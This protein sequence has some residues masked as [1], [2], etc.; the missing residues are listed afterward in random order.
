MGRKAL[1]E[2]SR[3][4]IPN[5]RRP[6]SVRTMRSRISFMVRLGD[7]E[8]TARAVDA[9]LGNGEEGRTAQLGAWAPGAEHEDPL[10]TRTYPDGL[11][12]REAEV[13]RRLA[14]GKTNNKIA[15]ELHVS[16]RTV[17]RH[18][19]NIY[20]KI[21]ARATANATAYALTHNLI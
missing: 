18:I 1:S 11:T 14:G 19:A 8:A 16:A 2:A 10:Q 20:A 17:E 7:A 13:L 5:A 9:F 21:C 4:E 15:E 6:A 12:A 3:G